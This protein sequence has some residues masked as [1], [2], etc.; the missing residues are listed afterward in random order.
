MADQFTED[1]FVTQSRDFL[2]LCLNKLIW[3]SRPFMFV[4]IELNWNLMRGN[5]RESDCLWLIFQ[6]REKKKKLEIN[7]DPMFKSCLFDYY[8][9]IKVS[10]KMSYIIY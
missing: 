2:N 7:T 6:R 5:E 10:F 3:L 8:R 9:K 1:L 4:W